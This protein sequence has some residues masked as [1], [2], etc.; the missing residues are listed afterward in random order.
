MGF[1]QICQI[2]NCS[3]F[4]VGNYATFIALVRALGRSSIGPWYQCFQLFQRYAYLKFKKS[5]VYPSVFK[6]AENDHN[7]KTFQKVKDSVM[8]TILIINMNAYC[9]YFPCKYVSKHRI[10]NVWFLAHLLAQKKVE[11]T[12]LICI[13][14]DPWGIKMGTYLYG[15]NSKHPWIELNETLI[16]KCSGI[17]ETH[18][19]KMELENESWL[20][21]QINSE[22]KLS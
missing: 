13:D 11:K 20:L 21:W 22:M 6:A 16:R 14:R 17:F 9:L 5:L 10:R 15:W 2:I 8:H 3:P 19:R 12:Q 18:S 4:R 7:V 1:C